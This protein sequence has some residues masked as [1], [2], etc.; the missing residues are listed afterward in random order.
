M[1]QQ[2]VEHVVCGILKVFFPTTAHSEP[3]SLQKRIESLSLLTSGE[4]LEGT[5]ERLREKV[6]LG[7]EDGLFLFYVAHG[8]DLCEQVEVAEA[9]PVEEYCSDELVQPFL[10]VEVVG[11]ELGERVGHGRNQ[12]P[13]GD[14]NQKHRHDD[15]VYLV[16]RVHR[17]YLRC[18]PQ[19]LVL[20]QPVLQE[21]E[22]KHSVQLVLHHLHLLFVLMIGEHAL[23]RLHDV[24]HIL[25][26]CFQLNYQVEQLLVVDEVQLFAFEL[27]EHFC[28]FLHSGVVCLEEGILH[29]VLAA[30]EHVRIFLR[31]HEEAVFD[32]VL[33]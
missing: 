15:V 24:L 33:V 4:S 22:E 11:D 30:A 2:S 6:A 18:D 14:L 32:V 31:K 3:H 16:M 23:L 25:S 10:V 5:P 21:T 28:H 29:F 26:Q 12:L 19:S 13:A 27:S 8:C 1:E 7:V 20:D 9:L 17:H